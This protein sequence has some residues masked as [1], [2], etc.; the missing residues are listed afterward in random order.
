M[1]GPQPVGGPG[2]SVRPGSPQHKRSCDR[3][4]RAERGERY[5]RHESVD[6]KPD[7]SM[8]AKYL[9]SASSLVQ[10]ALY[11]WSLPMRCNAGL[12]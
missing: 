1:Q 12:R 2:M 3:V 8:F 7:A 10:A 9:C 11:F 6:V 4:V 5:D